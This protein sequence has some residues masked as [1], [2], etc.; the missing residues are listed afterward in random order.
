MTVNKIDFNNEDDFLFAQVNPYGYW[1]KIKV[2][3]RMVP[4]I[5]GRKVNETEY[6]LLLD[7]RFIY[8]FSSFQDCKMA[9]TISANAMAIGE[10]YPWMGASKKERPFAPDVCVVEGGE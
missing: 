9:A 1:H 2:D 3:D 8:S 10:G 5:W 6:E 7:D 4:K